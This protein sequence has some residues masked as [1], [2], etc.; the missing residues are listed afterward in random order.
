MQ[1]RFLK[2]KVPPDARCHC[3][4]ASIPANCRTRK[5]QY[6]TGRTPNNDDGINGAKL[7]SHEPPRYEGMDDLFKPNREEP[8]H[9]HS[10][11]R[12]SPMPSPCSVHPS[13]EECCLGS[14]SEALK[15]ILHE[16]AFCQDESHEESLE[17]SHRTIPVR[18]RPGVSTKGMDEAELE[19]RGL[20]F[21]VLGLGSRV[22]DAGWMRLK[23]EAVL[24]VREQTESER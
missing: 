6:N 1:S 8:R 14:K 18:G 20:G 19:P 22:E 24:C 5:Y 10:S 17:R 11:P 2:I 3:T 12:H 15:R 23:D 9:H 16:V 13:Q 4:R 7:P 21:R